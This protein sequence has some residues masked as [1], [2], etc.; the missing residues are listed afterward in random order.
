[1]IYLQGTGALGPA[2][3]HQGLVTKVMMVSW[4]E[5]WQAWG[6]PQGSHKGI[7]VLG[8]IL[9]GRVPQHDLLGR[10]QRLRVLVVLQRL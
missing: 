8:P 5:S 10:P 6:I 4:K 7:L 3:G 9:L 1:M 2:R